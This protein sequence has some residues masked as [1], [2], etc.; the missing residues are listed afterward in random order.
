VNAN[1]DAFPD[2]ITTADPRSDGNRSDTVLYLND[3]GRRFIDTGSAG[4]MRLGPVRCLETT[5]WNHDGFTDVAMCPYS[6]SV[7]L[8]RATG[9]AG[10]TE[11]TSTI[12]VGSTA[13]KTWGVAFADLDHDGW[14]DMVRTDTKAVHVRRWNPSTKRFT[15]AQTITEV[16]AQAVAVGRF[17]EDEELDLYVVNRGC[18]E[19][20]PTNPPDRIHLGVGD[21]TFDYFASVGST[22]V[23]DFAAPWVAR[24]S[25]RASFVV[26]NGHLEVP[27]PLDLV[28][29]VPPV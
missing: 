12:G 13:A 5:D 18:A 14:D 7:R 26:G 21:G 10:F 23:G 20:T 17:D 16:D 29:W 11:V 3:A 2:L 27:G 25:G 1:G 8:F 19:C 6:G 4:L 15:A 28:T 22:G 24:G 9:A